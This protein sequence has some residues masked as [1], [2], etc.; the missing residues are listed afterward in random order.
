MDT[1]TEVK[2]QSTKDVTLDDLYTKYKKLQ[3]QLEF[4]AVQED[5]IKDEQRNLKKEYLHAQEEVKRIQSVPLVIGQFLEAVDQNTGIVGSTTGS[6]YYVRILSTLDRELLKPSA[7]VALHKHSNALV[8]VLPPEADSSISM[9]QAD[10]KPDV[11]YSDIGGMDMQKQEMKEAVELP[12]THFQLYKQI[13]IDPPRGVLMYGPPGNTSF[14]KSIK[15]ESRPW[16][17][18]IFMNL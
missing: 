5:Y 11:A 13:G 3:Q 7:S 2:V 10:E 16:E 9:L 18:L 12:L 1:G 15:T 8:D 6:N 17:N 4:L 14:T